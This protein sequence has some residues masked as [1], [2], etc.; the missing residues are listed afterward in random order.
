MGFGYKTKTRTMSTIPLTLAMKTNLL[1]LQSTQKLFDQTQVR[2]ATGKRVNSPMDDPANFFAA[3]TLTDRARDLE[4]RLDGMGQAV[5]ALKSA[6]NGISAI[7][8]VLDNMTAIVENAISTPDD[9]TSAKERQAL[10]KKF[11]ELLVQL[12]AFAKDSAFG[13]I[14]LLIDEQRIDLQLGQKFD[15]SVFSIQGFHIAGA[16][17]ASALNSEVAPLATGSLPSTW[18]G[19]AAQGVWAGVSNAAVSEFAFA[20]NK[21]E[22]PETFV[23]LKAFG[24]DNTGAGGHE[25]DWG[26]ETYRADLTNFLNAIEQLDDVLETRSKLFT[27]DQSTVSLRETYTQQFVN[28]LEEGADKLTLADLNEEAANLLALQTAQQLGTQALALTNQQTQGV[29]RLLG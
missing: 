2:L 24:T 16:T 15:E 29:L 22:D 25:V 28:A 10:G 18:G 17:V 11:N 12:N 4:D 26:S 14:N 8:S 27:F 21:V 5:Q 13:G 3:A 9:D 19:A 7:R 23:G 20:L 1:S 6:D